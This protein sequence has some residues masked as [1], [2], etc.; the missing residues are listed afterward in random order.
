[1]N[2]LLR[3]IAASAATA[4]LL[5]PAVSVCAGENPLPKGVPADAEVVA[6]L[7]T[8]QLIDSAP[9]QKIITK[10]R[11][12]E[13]LDD[14]IAV[15]KNLS[16][17]DV[18]RDIDRISMFG[19]LEDNE[20][21]GVYVEGRVD[22]EKLLTLL[23]AD[24][25]VKTATIAGQEVYKWMDKKEKREKFGA[26]LDDG[27]VA[28]WNSQRAAEAALAARTDTSKTFGA[29]PEASLVPQ[30]A[31]QSTAWLAIVSRRV[32]TPL[33]KIK[34][35]SLTAQVNVTADILDL[36]AR[37]EATT[38]EAGAHWVAVINGLVAFAQLQSEN[39]DLQRLGAATTT[40]LSS[41]NR[42][43]TADVTVNVNDIMRV[44]EE[45][46]KKKASKSE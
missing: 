11:A 27:T 12:T 4:L 15:L 22:K 6:S 20:F 28:V 23:K 25:E 29:T 8:R 17:I 38:P 2:H 30:D 10:L 46:H 34:A 3:R 43:V 40:S 24:T 16:G 41:D 26:F 13:G 36:K 31:T 9:V 39:A 32:G 44:L 45:G 19:R 35:K 7:N 18:L 1:M 14:K 21:V 42:T 33:E 5:A 37:L